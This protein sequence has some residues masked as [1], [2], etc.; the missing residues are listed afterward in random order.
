MAAG[1]NL[2]CHGGRLIRKWI[3]QPL[4]NSKEIEYRLDGVEE[5]YDNRILLD[6]IADHLKKVYDLERLM[7][8]I[9]YGTPMPVI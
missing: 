4:I 9:S 6:D 3:Q 2:H 5:L 1:Q 7:A 8:R